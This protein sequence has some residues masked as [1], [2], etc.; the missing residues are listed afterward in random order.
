MAFKRVLAPVLTLLVVLA[1][2]AAA[3]TD[4]LDQLIQEKKII[5]PADLAAAYPEAEAVYILDE[6]DTDQSRIINPVNVTRH[7]VLKVLKESAIAKLR[8][9]KIPIYYENRVVDMVARTI[10]NG[11]ISKVNDIPERE[12]DLAGQDRDFVYPLEQ[13]TTMYLLRNEELNTNASAGDLLKINENPVLHD[14]R[15]KAY[16]IREITFPD[17]QVGSVLEYEYKLEQKRAVLYDRFLFMKEYPV[18]K[19]NFIMR[20]SKMLHFSYEPNNFSV[21]PTLVMDDRFN[22][23]E[24]QYNTDVR[25]KL[26]TIDVSDSP[27]K[28]QFFGHQYF[29]VS[30]DTVPAYPAKVPFVAT[31][32]DISPRIDAFMRDAV[33]VIKYT[34]TEYRL[35][36][37]FFSQ[38]WNHVLHRMTMNYLTNERQARQAKTDIA[39]AIA[40]ASTPEEKVTAAVSWA[41]KN[42]K[43][44]PD[45]N[46]WE[47]FYWSSKPQTPDNL[48]RAKAGNADDINFFLVSAL[49]LNGLSVYPAYAKSRNRGAF[50]MKLTIE[51]QFDSPL[52]ALEVASRRFKFWQPACEVAM[53]ADYIDPALEGVMA[54]V[55]QSGENDVTFVNAEVPILEPE[56]SKEEIEA[57]LT[58]AADGTLSGQLK[59][60]NSGHVAA[61]V[62]QILTAAGEAGSQAAWAA[63]IEGMFDNLSVTGGYKADDPTQPADGFNVSADVSIK[64]AARAVSGN[65]ALKGAVLT[66]PFTSRLTGEPREY[67]VVVPYMGDFESTVNLAL[68]AGYSVLD[69]LPAPLELRTKGFFYSRNIIS[70]GAKLQIKR[71]FS[72]GLQNIAARSYDT[73]YANLFK[74]IRDAENAEIILKKK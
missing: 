63:G 58:L 32:M 31:Y 33:N 53:P 21:K 25:N 2:N 28:W 62:K 37:T 64:G 51:T 52:I 7:V 1:G 41:R 38:S 35:R 6:K 73:R 45:L 8:T 16:K 49:Q 60:S 54:I 48:L 17:V 24:T 5:M 14:K 12:V 36:P 46:R 67:N 23:I 26:R 20:N 66:D 10:N 71:K 19:A 56:K 65:L 27:D 69:S 39:S 68:P 13:G 40:G 55:N 9:V 34:D 42:I 47:A 43:L 22:N 11:Q 57:S 15:E 74:Q 70:D 29:E 4:N 59:Q 72:M 30:L 3:L 44:L 18:L 61:E 50:D